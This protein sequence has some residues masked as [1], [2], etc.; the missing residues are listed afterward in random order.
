MAIHERSAWGS[1][2]AILVLYIPYF[3]EVNAHPMESLY[4]FWMVGIGMAVIMGVF[5]LIDTIVHVVQ[6]R[7]IPLQILDELDRTIQYKAMMVS[8]GVLAFAL[9]IWVI[10]MMY[11]LPILGAT[12]IETTSER[13]NTYVAW[14]ID[15]VM[16][17]I[18]WLFAGF[19]LA[20]LVF[21][22]AV[23]VQYRGLHRAH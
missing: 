21:Y 4:R 8:G 16:R 20:N 18:Q 7:R 12:V 1:I 11:A 3:I 6:T 15:H 23:I 2:G 13:V 22:L 14:P 19:V 9:V 5:H 17:A 10:V